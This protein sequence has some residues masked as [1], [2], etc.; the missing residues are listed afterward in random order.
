MDDMAEA[1]RVGARLPEDQRNL[2]LYWP[3]GLFNEV[4]RRALARRGL[5][6]GRT[7][8]QLGRDV[9][10]ALLADPSSTRERGE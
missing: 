2:L 1:K 9:I 3:K 5:I 10:A 6:A 7:V 8:T 4:T